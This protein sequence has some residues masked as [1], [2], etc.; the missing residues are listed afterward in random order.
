VSTF[1]VAEVGVN[2]NGCLKTAKELIDTASNC[3]AD[4]VK[5]QS[6]VTEDL[7]A[8]FA[9]K[10]NYQKLNSNSNESQF[11]MLKRYELSEEDHYRLFDYCNK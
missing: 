1:I 7:V 6:Y 2:H 9:E 4:A 3:G 8:K 5:F 10:A 11:D